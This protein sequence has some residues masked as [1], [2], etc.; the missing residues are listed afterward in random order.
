M[1]I[2]EFLLGSRR[3]NFQLVTTSFFTAFFL[4]AFAVFP[5][6]NHR[7]IPEN[8][9]GYEYPDSVMRNRAL[10]S[11]GGMATTYTGMILFM[12]YI[13]YRGKT[14][15]PFHFYNDNGHWLQMD[16]RGHAFSGFHESSTAYHALRW[17]GYP[18]KTA[19]WFGGSMGFF[20]QAP[21]DIWDGF[22]EGYGFSWGDIAANAAGAA[23]FVT[24]EAIWD[25]QFIRLKF[26]YSPSGYS[27]YNPVELGETP[28]KSFFLDYNGHTY[29]VSGSINRLTGIEAFPAWLCISIGQS[30]GGMT[31]REFNLPEYPHV[32]RYRQYFLSLDVDVAQMNI[33]N[34]YL[35]GFLYLFNVLKFPAPA[36]EYNRINGFRV[37]PIY[38]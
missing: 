6:F 11:V 27:H 7:A 32:E 8:P 26:S 22:Y 34:P 35:R 29:W 5:Q 15:A 1:K 13:W 2:V 10:I 18:K 23:M 14:R 30:A 19:L 21:V 16:K 17:A 37:R 38:Y 25:E 33:K 31:D 3:N 12:E 9:Y 20:L 28:I 4:Y 24:Q 36:L